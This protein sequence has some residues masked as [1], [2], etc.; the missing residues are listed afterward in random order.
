MA[1]LETTAADARA[2]TNGL[3]DEQINWRR[4]PDAWSIAECLMHLTETSAVYAP[5]F[6][7]V[8]GRARERGRTGTGPF[9]MNWT[10]HWFAGLL[11]P[12]PKRR[13]KAPRAFRPRHRTRP[14]GAVVRDHAEANRTIQNL[15]RSADGLHL[16]RIRMASPLTPLLRF[17]LDAAF[18][19]HAAHERRH[20]WQARQVRE[21]EGFPA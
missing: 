6:E 3:S 7:R 15:V 9:T 11:E 8:I 21:A 17:N 5:A 19:I 2:L 14:A 18:R 12:P 4:A 10:G 1:A 20:L 16:G 13:F